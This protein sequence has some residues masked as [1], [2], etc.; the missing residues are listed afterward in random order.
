MAHVCARGG[1]LQR[2]D[3]PGLPHRGSELQANNLSFFASPEAG[4][5]QNA[6]FD[7]GITQ[8][9]GLV[10]RSDAEPFRSFGLQS[11]GT[12]HRAMAVGIGLYD[13][14]YR[15]AGP[16]MLYNRAEVLPQSGQGN[17]GP[18]GTGGHAARNFYSARH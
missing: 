14:A 10:E 5:Q 15:D 16:S 8:R 7:I 3:V 18:C 2:L 6:G 11:A 13:G 17:L 9:D 1:G 12:L 4:H